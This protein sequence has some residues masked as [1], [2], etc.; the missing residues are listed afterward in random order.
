MLH[1]RLIRAL[2]CFS[3]YGRLQDQFNG[4]ESILHGSEEKV[5][6]KIYAGEENGLKEAGH[7]S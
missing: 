2:D 6:F 3:Y 1:A 4:M 5:P 7:A